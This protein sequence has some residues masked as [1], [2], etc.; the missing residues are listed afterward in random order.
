MAD[1]QSKA[2]TQGAGQSGA[3][4]VVRQANHVEVLDDNLGPQLL[5][6]GTVTD[7]PQVVALLRTQKAQ[8]LVREV[9]R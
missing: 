9:K 3:P 5:K 8:K 7:D 6:K 2:P 4:N 1:E